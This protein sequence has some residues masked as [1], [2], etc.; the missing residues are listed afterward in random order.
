AGADIR[1]DV[2]LLPAITRVPVVGY[3]ALPRG[4]GWGRRALSRTRRGSRCC[5]ARTFRG[6]G[7]DR[8]LRATVLLRLALLCLALLRLTLLLLP[9]AAL[10]F[11]SC[12]L[13]RDAASIVLRAA[14]GGFLFLDAAAVLRLQMLALAPLGLDALALAARDFLG[15]APLL[16]DLVLLLA[17]LL[18]EH[19]ALDV[20]ALLT[21]LDTDRARAA[22]GA[23]ELQ[24]ALRLAL[25]RDAA[26]RG[27]ALAALRVAVAAAKVCQQLELGIV[28]DAVIGTF[29]LDAGLIE[30]HEQPIHGHLQDLGK[31][32]NRHFRH[33]YRSLLR[34]VPPGTRGP[35]L[36]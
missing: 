33:T 9:L 24:L 27:I 13:L 22:L 30:L 35:G 6:C 34:P 32:G 3:G 11:L 2:Q 17:R 5:S 18:L 7:G 10:L 26:G 25:E 15:L 14:A 31:L 8:L 4:G 19:V 12:A 23:R 21:D 16:V 36:S 29:D 28:A 1:C 20:G